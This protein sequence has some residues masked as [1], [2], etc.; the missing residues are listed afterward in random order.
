MK[1]EIITEENIARYL[2][3]LSNEEIFRL[4]DSGV[5]CFGAYDEDTGQGLGTLS[6]EILPEYIRI[7]RLYV[8]PEKRGKK[9]GTLLMDAATNL[10][11][12]MDMPI[13]VF[14]TERDINDGFL[15]ACGFI[16]QES[17][18]SYIEGRLSDLI[19]LPL[20]QKKDGY[21]FLTLNDIPKEAIID[22][23]ISSEG[24]DFRKAADLFMNL[25]GFSEGSPVCGEMI[26]RECFIPF[27]Y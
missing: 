24:D 10:P 16:M 8:S 3:V 21:R 14:G 9:V 23:V 4:S 13:Y 6:A 18:C 25:E 27:Q 5:T 17:A 1:T 15:K 11:D 20:P 22:F 19:D 7:N 12:G 2:E 26:I